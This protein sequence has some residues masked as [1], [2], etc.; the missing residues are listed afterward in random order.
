[1]C[2]CKG[3]GVRSLRG[4]ED[5]TGPRAGVSREASDGL[6]PSMGVTVETQKVYRYPFEQVVA[7]YLR[8]VNGKGRGSATEARGLDRP[9]PCSMSASK[10]ALT[11]CSRSKKAASRPEASRCVHVAVA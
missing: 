5:G 1:M 3:E 4:E 2:L 11:S 9:A 10:T 8:K 6:A 7:S